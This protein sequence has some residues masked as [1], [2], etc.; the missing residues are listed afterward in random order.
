MSNIITRELVGRYLRATSMHQAFEG[1]LD[2]GADLEALV[3]SLP[4][5][6]HEARLGMLAAAEMLSARAA[7]LE[8]ST[9]IDGSYKA[10]VKQRENK[11]EAYL[12][13][14]EAERLIEAAG[15]DP[16]TWEATR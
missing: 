12:L 5:R 15:V 6:W 2:D 14:N 1:V 8:S 16:K 4:G 13:R 11:R 3:A 9:S 10:A 7:K